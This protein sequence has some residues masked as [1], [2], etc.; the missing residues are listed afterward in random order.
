MKV[1]DKITDIFPGISSPFSLDETR[2]RTFQQVRVALVP[3]QDML[4]ASTVVE[5]GRARFVF[6]GRYASMMIDVDG[7]LWA[8]GCNED[9]ILGIGSG[10][11]KQPV[12]VKVD[13]G[14]KRISH[15]AGGW[16]HFLAVTEDGE[17]LS[18]FELFLVSFVLRWHMAMGEY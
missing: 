6:A 10:V 12:P 2:A 9:G 4:Y 11:A 3:L 13:T 8:W 1:V 16:K 7:E 14:G 15:A 18:C 5:G 17:L